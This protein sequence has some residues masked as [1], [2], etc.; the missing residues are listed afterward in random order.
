MD[1]PNRLFECS[2]YELAASERTPLFVDYLNDLVAHHAAHSVHYR[3][4]LQ[5]LGVEGKRFERIEDFPYVPVRLFKHFPLKSVDDSAVLKTLT[6][7]GTTGQALSRIFIDNGTSALQTR[8]LSAIVQ[9]YLGKS[10]AP[11]I[12]VD[13]HSVIKDR[14][15]FSA[16]G[17]GI[18]GLSPFGRDH[19][20]ALDESMNPDVDGLIAYLSK[21]SGQNIFMFGFTFMIWK[22]FYEALAQA[23]TRIDLS[24]A[25]L[26]HS[27][28]WKKLIAESVDNQT[29]KARLKER[30]GLSRIYNFY[31][32]VEQMGSV[33]M[34]CDAGYLHASHFS[35][36]V[37]RDHVDW[38]AVPNGREGVIEVASILPHSYPGHVL[39]T[40]DLGVV[41]GEDDCQCG[42]KGK[43]F[44]IRGRIPKAE[45]RGCSDTYET[46]A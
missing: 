20:Y 5:A 11:M 32:M 7:S 38:S 28:G 14:T 9:S 40:E 16:R 25:T 39:L 4:L 42:R 41:F 23:A 1:F 30:F 17:G 10:R 27:G 3:R 8:A 24:N 45:V 21:H 43:Y 46:A 15:L 18:L 33:F 2:P 31:G 22:H 37:V 36:I 6:S 29:F 12:I 26:I 44:E 34:E 35:D 19:F 13:S